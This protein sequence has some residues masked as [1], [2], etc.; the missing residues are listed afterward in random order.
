VIRSRVRSDQLAVRCRSFLCTEPPRLTLCLSE[1]VSR[2]VV[3]WPGFLLSPVS[4]GEV[5]SLRRANLILR[6]LILANF[7]PGIIIAGPGTVTIALRCGRSLMFSPESPLLS[8]G[9]DVGVCGVVF[10]GAWLDMRAISLGEIVSLC[11]PNPVLWWGLVLRIYIWSV[12][13]GTRNSG[14]LFFENFNRRFQSHRL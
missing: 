4:H 6:R 11:R 10:A 3:A 1:C 8:I 2:S 7:A 13:A 14:G 12:G 5:E 9:L